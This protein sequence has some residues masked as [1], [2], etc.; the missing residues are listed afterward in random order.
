MY[1]HP[2]FWVYME[3]TCPMEASIMLMETGSKMNGDH[4]F[5]DIMSLR[6]Q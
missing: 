5:L 3:L 6:G 2:K 1:S 4:Y